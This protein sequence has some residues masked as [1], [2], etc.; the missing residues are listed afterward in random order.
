MSDPH[1]ATEPNDTD[2]RN[3]PAPVASDETSIAEH[4]EPNDTSEPNE[5][6]EPHD[7][8]TRSRDAK[9]HPGPHRV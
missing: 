3:E 6:S 9:P 1:D 5:P 4:P 7:A 8:F 2:E